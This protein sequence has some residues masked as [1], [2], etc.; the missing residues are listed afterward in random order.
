MSKT[1]NIISANIRF[2]NKND[3]VH[4]WENR[5]PILGES[6]ESFGPQFIGTQEGYRPQLYSLNS[7]LQEMNIVDS[8]RSWITN[9][10]YPSLFV[11]SEQ[12]F[13][14]KSGDIWL[15]ETINCRK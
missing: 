14:K 12:M 3:G 13:V 9:R 10:M 8:H 6:I 4:I 11:K 5:K 2:D 7:L 15:S 1:L